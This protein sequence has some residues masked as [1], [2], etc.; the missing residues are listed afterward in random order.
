M[1]VPPTPE[2]NTPTR[3]AAPFFGRY[4]FELPGRAWR[5]VVVGGLLIALWPPIAERI[6]SLAVAAQVPS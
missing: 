1:A 2:T 6:G 3:P 4:E 5:A